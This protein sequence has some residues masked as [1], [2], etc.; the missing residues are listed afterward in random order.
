[1]NTQEK[2]AAIEEGFVQSCEKRVKSLSP[3][4]MTYFELHR[5]ELFYIWGFAFYHRKV[6][7]LIESA[8]KN[9]N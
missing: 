2:I 7:E 6:A 5:D 3:E 9:D 1:M 8:N 4:A